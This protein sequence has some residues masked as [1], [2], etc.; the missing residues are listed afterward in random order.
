MSESEI[1]GNVV[2]HEG[3]YKVSNK[4]NVQTYQGN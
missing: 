2:G 1:W 4:G 3:F